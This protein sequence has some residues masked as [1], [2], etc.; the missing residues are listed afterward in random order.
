MIGFVQVTE[1]EREQVAC[2][3][4]GFQWEQLQASCF[5]IHPLTSASWPS[6]SVSV[7]EP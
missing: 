3:Q 5:S 2:V 1:S 4:G 7:G 6:A